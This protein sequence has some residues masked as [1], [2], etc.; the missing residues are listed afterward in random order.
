MNAATN[1]MTASLARD[2]LELARLRIASDPAAAP[3][4]GELA[5]DAGL[6]PSQ[7]TRRFR[8]RFGLSPADYA[9][10]L[11][12]HEFKRNLRDG[13]EVTDAIYAAGFGSPSRVYEDTARLIGMTPGAYRRGGEGLAIRYTILDTPIGRVLVAATERGVCAIMPGA[14]DAT[15]EQALAD[16]FPKA[17][18]TRVDEG[19][20]GW[21]A[22]VVGR[23][24]AQFADAA[25]PAR[26][27]PADLRATAF[28]WQV[29]NALTRIPSGQT[30]SY[31]EVA[32]EIGRPTAAR[33]VARACASNRLAL[34][35][36]CHRVI[37]DDGS[38]GG[39]RW[40]L[41]AK[42]ALLRFEREH[43]SRASTHQR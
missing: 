10:A 28:Q 42:D 38:M 43:L 25:Q 8:A 39:Y 5:S 35:V 6:S 13:S 17:A 4:L 32:R 23:I 9:R 22:E 19:A 34:I 21:L 15:L 14:S 7:F 37:R 26:A 27:L 29:W 11:R 12:M 36:P 1:L 18:R 31:A 20:D 41:Q 33:A 24:A 30:R 3:A 16:E 40:G 2:P